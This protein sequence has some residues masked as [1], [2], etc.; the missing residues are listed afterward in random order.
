MEYAERKVI[1]CPSQVALIDDI[2]QAQILVKLDDSYDGCTERHLKLFV[3]KLSE[4]LNLKEGVLQLVSV[5]SGCFEL[6]FQVPLFVQQG[7]F[8]LS[9]EQEKSL[10][11]LG[12]FKSF[13]VDHTPTVAVS[14]M[15]K[16]MWEMMTDMTNQMMMT[17]QL[18]LAQL[19]LN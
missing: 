9:L 4:V 17:Q 13:V 11:Q 5:K 7:T 1:E 14:S 12:V 2:N 16:W 6:T 3:G 18:R 15:I 19:D 10:A 8:P